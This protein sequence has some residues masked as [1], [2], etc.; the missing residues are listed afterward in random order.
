MTKIKFCGL[1]DPGDILAANQ[2]KADYVGFVFAPGSRRRIG[3][4]EAERLKKLLDPGI[5]AA[6]Q[7][8]AGSPG[9]SGCC[10][11]ARGPPGT[12]CPPPRRGG[13]DKFLSS[14][15]LF[16]PPVF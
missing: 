10:R 8:V 13:S 14:L 11:T 16:F 9:A 3:R 6:G 5:G 12:G 4:E 7:Q 2:L 1:S 15:P